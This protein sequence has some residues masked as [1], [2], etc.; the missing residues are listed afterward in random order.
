MCLLLFPLLLSLPLRQD[1]DD[2]AWNEL[3]RV[4][5]PHAAV[6]DFL[7]R[8]PSTQ[9]L[10]RRQLFHTGAAGSRALLHSLDDVDD[11]GVCALL[12]LLARF[13][14]PADE[15]R[16]KLERHVTHDSSAIRAAAAAVIGA[17]PT[18]GEAEWVRLL[19]RDPREVVR[20]AL[21][22]SR[23]RLEFPRVRDFAERFTPELCACAV[24]ADPEL[25]SAAARLLLLVD[26]PEA[27]HALLDSSPVASDWEKDEWL[28]RLV[29]RPP[30]WPRERLSAWVA[31]DCAAGT[32]RELRGRLLLEKLDQPS[33]WTA[34]ERIEVW[35]SVLDPAATEHEAAIAL[36][37][38]AGRREPAAFVEHIPTLAPHDGLQKAYEMALRLRGPAALDDFARWLPTLE[39]TAIAALLQTLTRVPSEATARWL[40]EHNSVFWNSSASPFVDCTL[41]QPACG[42]REEL[43]V[44][45]L[46]CRDSHA[47]LRAFESLC[48]TG[49]EAHLDELIATLDR[50]TDA[51]NHE[52]RLQWLADGFG[53]A[54][55]DRI[56]DVLRGW[57]DSEKADEREAALS[58]V[59][60]L[61]LG[62]RAE[63]V[64]AEL[65][66]R[67]RESAPAR[68]MV[69]LAQIGGP[70]AEQLLC[71]RVRATGAEADRIRVFLLRQAGRLRGE[72]SAELLRETLSSNHAR[73]REAAL[74][75][76]LERS[77]SAA[78]KLGAEVLR[79][80]PTSSQSALLR[81]FDPM[82]SNAGF[83]SF[84]DALPAICQ[85][86]DARLAMLELAMRW[87][88][89]RAVSWAWAMLEE[90]NE[91]ELHE[92]AL[93]ALAASPT[94]R[95]LERWRAELAPLEGS[96]FELLG[97]RDRQLAR[98]RAAALA[99]ASTKTD[100]GARAVLLVLTTAESIAGV[101]LLGAR[102]HA[103]AEPRRV[104]VDPELCAAL[105]RCEP[106]EVRQALESC[107]DNGLHLLWRE[108]FL[109]TVAESLR[110][111]GAATDTQDLFRTRCARQ[112]PPNSAHDLA[113]EVQ[114]A[115]R[116][117]ASFLSGFLDDLE[118]TQLTR[119]ADLQRCFWNATLERPQ[120]A[121]AF[122]R[123]DPFFDWHP[124]RTVR[125]LAVLATD[126]G[127]SAFRSETL[128]AAAREAGHH[129]I[130]LAG[131]AELAL[132]VD[133]ALADE[134][135]QRALATAPFLP[136]AL[137][138]CA[139]VRHLQGRGPER[140][141]LCRR[142][143]ES[144]EI[145]LAPP[146]PL[147]LARR[148]LYGLD[149]GDQEGALRLLQRALVQ[150]PEL[151]QRLE[152]DRSLHPLRALLQSP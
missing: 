140:D 130:L 129:A 80:L 32:G 101:G 85:D 114:R 14:V 89:E 102:L 62:D 115:K 12:E 88:P 8:Q 53:A 127:R 124:E 78:L 5:D 107:L 36:L 105:A 65:H 16:G 94:E 79:S 76:L 67:F 46:R 75:A 144:I 17:R 110:A 106:L 7:G 122:H 20:R 69:V 72:E 25:R 34:Q 47:R 37:A 137:G 145:G 128:R 99:W 87:S 45:A 133:L 10:A 61:A 131:L 108:S 18:E 152:R 1:A 42:A 84:L 29:A 13:P 118:P 149:R 92:P 24:A 57:M 116:E 56:L 60:Y 39:P 66:D 71:D 90:E 73:E 21:L 81:D 141:D 23:A 100:G 50:S 6:E 151:R 27:A 55:R 28:D 117:H 33:P 41:M 132:D 2:A 35:H 82:G 138:L 30:L 43:L 91:S 103:A 19:L 15:L 86:D 148:A 147:N 38:R 121:A 54:H 104:A 136:Q 48:R 123:R 40:H 96:P 142:E 70:R 112:W 111:H 31:S 93:R 3:F 49:A 59:P 51:R 26:G 134:L 95:A 135:G 113:V 146:H 98:A 44:R 58:A 9:D 126:A 74:R 63:A 4:R 83:P 120:E 77:D 97:L 109:L 150:A 139:F 52:R 143:R 119:F 64:A 125:T 22:E 11:A 68:L